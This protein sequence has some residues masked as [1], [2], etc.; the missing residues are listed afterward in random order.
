MAINKWN[1]EFDTYSGKYCGDCDHMRGT[2]RV[3]KA[4]K[5]LFHDF[6]PAC[7]KGKMPKAKDRYKDFTV[8]PKWKQ[9][10][11]CSDYSEGKFLLEGDK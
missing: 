5:I 11:H 8:Y 4:G 2:L 7:K 10:E 9:A 1:T 3:T 6:F